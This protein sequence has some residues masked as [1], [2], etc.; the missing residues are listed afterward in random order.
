LDG[1]TTFGVG[2]TVIV[3]F[4]NIPRQ[5]F[6]VGL[7]KI[8]AVT[9]ATV[10]LVAAKEAM[11][12]RPVPARPIDVVVLLHAYVVPVVVLL[13]LNALWVAPLQTAWFPGTITFG[14]G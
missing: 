11:L 9:G 8:V 1:T 4:C 12:P 10:L 6:A 13:K 14:V 5:P 2:F 3:K 7:T